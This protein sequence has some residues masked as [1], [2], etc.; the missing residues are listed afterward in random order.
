M[1]NFKDLTGQKFG[2]LTVIKRVENYIRPSG[3]AA[4]K[5]L[6]VCD[7]GNEI[8]VITNSLTSKQTQSCGCLHKEIISATF[9]KYNIYDI[10][11]DYGIGYTSKGE[12]FYFDL[13][14]YDKIKNYCWFVDSQGYISARCNNKQHI[15]FHRV[16]FP[17]SATVDHITHNTYDNRKCNLRVATQSQNNINRGIMKNNTSGVTGV[18]WQKNDRRWVARIRINKK[19]IHLGCFINFKDAVKAR[20]DAEEKYFGEFSYDNSMKVG[21]KYG[22]MSHI[23]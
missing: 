9:K 12:E 7:C 13:E 2:K 21:E 1:A 23:S 14:D 16:L 5:W 10:T 22:N 4:A 19:L 8:E 6:C 3:K 11:G 20:K 17:D 18:Y 15:L